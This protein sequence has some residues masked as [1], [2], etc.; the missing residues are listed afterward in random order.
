[1]NGLRIGTAAWAIPRAVADAFPSEGS[2][3]QR[4][5]AVFNCVEINSSFYRSHKPETYARWAASVGAD[6]RFAVKLPRTITHEA[7]LAAPEMALDQFASE[8]GGLGPKLG[9]VLMQLPPSLAFD[10][11]VARMAL[12]ALRTRF[13]CLLACEARHA[14][15]FGQ[16]A[17]ELLREFGVTR[18]IADPPVG[19][20][21][22]YVATAFTAYVRLHGSPRIYFSSYEPE[23]LAQVRDWLATQ[24]AAWCVFDNTASGAATANALALQR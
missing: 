16:A 14:T 18:V 15:W 1:M 24:P 12:A 2:A 10:P 21:G 7:R 20:R 13:A 5:A 6:F 22:P 3:L 11:A 9:S 19:E 8:A 17:T 23:R 4:Y